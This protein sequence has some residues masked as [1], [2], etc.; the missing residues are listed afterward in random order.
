MSITR[1]FER[2]HY[3]IDAID[4]CLRWSSWLEILSY[5]SF[6]PKSSASAIVLSRRA[7]RYF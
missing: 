2:L 7:E 4:Q 3:P 1:T 5:I 6:E